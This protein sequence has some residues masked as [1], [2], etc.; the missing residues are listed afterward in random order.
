VSKLNFRHVSLAISLVALFG[1]HAAYAQ[2][3]PTTRMT[4]ARPAPAAP[5][6]LVR[7]ETDLFSATLAGRYAQGTDNAALAAQA[8]S[9]AFMRRPGDVELFSKAL[10]AN[11]Q[12]G[13]VANA[14]RLSKAL[15]PSLRTDDA[16]LVL[17]VDA[18]TNERY[19]E[20][21]R[22]LSGRS[23]Q[24]SQRVLADHL[25]SYALLGQGKNDDGVN[26]SSRSSGLGPIDKAAL[27]SRAIIHDQAGR[28]E[29]AE[30]L[31]QSAIDGGVRW[32]VGVRAYGD[33]LLRSGKKSQAIGLYQRVARA[34]GNEAGGFLVAKARAEADLTPRKPALRAAASAG[35]ISLAQS[36]AG[37]GRG[38]PPLATLN[39]FAT[40]D[41]SSDGA[42]LAV[43]DQLVGE[44]KNALALPI[45]RQIGPTSL[46]YM[47]ARNE[48][49]WAVF[50]TNKSEA[51]ALARETVAALPN[52]A[53]AMRLLA[54]VLA[55]NRND[56]EAEGL[57]T[58]LIDSGKASGETNEV[59]WPLYF[60]RGGARERLG[61][62]PAARDD[63]RLA[64]TAAPNQPSVLNYLG[65]ALA[66]RGESIEEALTLLRAAVRL[67]P[68]SGSI[69]DSLGWAQFKAGRYEEA[70]AT[71]EKASSLEGNLAE[72]S[73]HLGDA[74]WRT[75]RQD[76]AR[77]EWARTLR[78]ET[79]PSQREAVSRKL[80]VGLPADPNAA[81]A[82]AVAVQS[83]VSRPQ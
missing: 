66:D 81:A 58:R 56:Q 57:Y 24:P 28:S 16:V 46:D 27:M 18:F 31:F 43:A 60:G 79:T 38:G 13:D 9:R 32:P 22:L 1:G 55:A 71:L 50:E 83:G 78:L 52:Q 49:V 61:N 54:D 15:A 75:G 76:E 25:N 67:R 33:L 4:A 68:R 41:P 30:I 8:W 62:W 63:L 77:I 20:V 44:N 59:L 70:V 82:R 74:Y 21:S 12:I 19:G 65:Y 73:E 48:L 34:G 69:L 37:E 39:L 72:I 7:P 10:T 6:T 26:A 35:M 23:F 5:V 40:L 2:N 36:L 53:A 3:R 45:L 42:R 17:S 11:L 64:K 14:I 51:V 29:E 80:Q 47:A